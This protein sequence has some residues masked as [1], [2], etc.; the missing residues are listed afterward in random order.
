MTSTLL[1]DIILQDYLTQQPADEQTLN[2]FV[3]FTKDWLKKNCVGLSYTIE[4][5]ALRVA[6][7][8]EYLLVTTGDSDTTTPAVSIVGGLQTRGQSAMPDKSRSVSIIGQ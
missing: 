3:A 7:G 4:G 2:N 6:N 5:I 8:D 1:L